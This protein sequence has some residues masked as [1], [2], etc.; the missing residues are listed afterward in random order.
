VARWRRDPEPVVVP[1]WVF[2]PAF[3]AEAG[4]WLDALYEQDTERWYEAFVEIIS[5]PT[6]TRPA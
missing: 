5:T 3:E 1:A 6:Y 2:D 4:A